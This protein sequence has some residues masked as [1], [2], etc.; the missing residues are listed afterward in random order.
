MIDIILTEEQAS[1]ILELWNANPQNPPFLRDLSK[2]AFGREVDGRSQEGKAIKEFLTTQNLAPKPAAPKPREDFELTDAQKDFISNN[3]GTMNSLEL[4]KEIYANPKLS[5]LHK[6]TRLVNDHLKTL[7]KKAIYA[8]TEE[9]PIEAFYRAPR[10]Q[11]RMLYKINKYVHVGIDKEKMTSRQ[12]KEIQ[13]LIGY[14]NTYRFG[15][16]INTYTTQSDRELFESSFVRYTH[17]KSDLT[18]EE[19]DQYIVLCTE[20]VISSSI[21]AAIVRLED[22]LNSS[23]DNPDNVK[24]SMSLVEAISTARTEYNQ[25]VMRQQKLLNDLKEKRSDRLRNS[26]KENASILNL[27]IM[28]KEEESRQKLLKLAELRKQS[29]KN[30][31]ERLTTMDD[32]KCRILGISPEEVLNG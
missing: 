28:F 15:H 27:V 5:N 9:V 30:E 4:A 1:K 3:A 19:V 21:Q 31:I 16:Q 14:V 20:V 32:V 26:I 25:C 12:K 11:D 22:L 23:T 6:E 29:V 7:D 10:T 24:I 2:A 13:A 18:Q 17:D 8:D